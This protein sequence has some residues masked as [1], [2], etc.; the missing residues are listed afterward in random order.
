MKKAKKPA[1]SEILPSR[2]AL[3]SLTKGDSMQRTMNNYAKKTPSSAA[4]FGFPSLM[5]MGRR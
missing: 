1:K 5:M 2:M 3:T 4:A